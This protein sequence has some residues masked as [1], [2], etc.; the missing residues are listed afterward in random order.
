[1]Y[2]KKSFFKL[3]FPSKFSMCD[4]HINFIF[5]FGLVGLHEGDMWSIKSLL[6]HLHLHFVL[7]STLCEGKLFSRLPDKSQSLFICNVKWCLKFIL[8]YRDSWKL[9][10][11]HIWWSMLLVTVVLFEC[12]SFIV[13]I[14]TRIAHFRLETHKISAKVQIR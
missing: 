4:I 12:S 2:L 11:E 6:L 10:F 8:Y 9:F 3:E 13:P 7:F 14:H 1:M 5:S